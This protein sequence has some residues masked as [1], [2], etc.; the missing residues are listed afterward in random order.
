M[1]GDAARLVGKVD[2]R[3]AREAARATTTSRAMTVR[4][5]GRYAESEY[6]GPSSR[7]ATATAADQGVCADSW[8]RQVSRSMAASL[9]LTRDSRGGGGSR[10]CTFRSDRSLSRNTRLGLFPAPTPN[11]ST[12]PSIA[13]GDDKQRAPHIAP[14]S[15]AQA[16]SAIVLTA[17]ASTSHSG[18]AG[19]KDEHEE[20]RHRATTEYLAALWENGEHGVQSCTAACVPLMILIVL[21]DAS[22]HASSRSVST[23]RQT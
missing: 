5:V 11:H 23:S 17:P 7:L 15:H 3:M 2:I 9:S 18:V 4:W 13:A 20:R 10:E 8:R 21:P 19:V 1:Q 6:H 14:F 16:R 22:R 12:T